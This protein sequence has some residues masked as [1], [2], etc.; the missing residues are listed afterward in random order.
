MRLD[1]PLPSLMPQMTEA[2]IF[3]LL[4][5][6]GDALP[7]GAPRFLVTWF[8]RRRGGELTAPPAPVS[9]AKPPYFRNRPALDQRVRDLG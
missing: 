8:A 6:A 3:R 9:S 2:K 7:I 5:A 1:L 4:A